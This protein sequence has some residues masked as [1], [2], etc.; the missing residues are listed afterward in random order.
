MFNPFQTFLDIFGLTLSDIDSCGM[1]CTGV[2]TSY[3]GGSVTGWSKCK[4]SDFIVPTGKNY[5][6]L[7]T[8]DW[9]KKIRLYTVVE[10]GV[11]YSLCFHW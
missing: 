8:A 2:S 6:E 4:L 7:S 11:N 1:Y 10:N 5:P 9:D 3:P